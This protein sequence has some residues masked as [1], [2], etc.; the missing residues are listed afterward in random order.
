MLR[1]VQQAQFKIGNGRLISFGNTDSHDL[2]RNRA[3]WRWRTG[4]WL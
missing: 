2:V 3:R 4:P 1:R